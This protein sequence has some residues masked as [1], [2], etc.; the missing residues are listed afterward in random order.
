MTIHIRSAV[1]AIILLHSVSSGKWLPA[2]ESPPDWVSSLALRVVQETVDGEVTAETMKLSRTFDG[3]AVENRVQ[4]AVSPDGNSVA[5]RTGASPK[6]AE[7]LWVASRDDMEGRPLL[8][9]RW[10]M[11]P[12]KWSPDGTR[13]ACI[14]RHFDELNL[15]T[16]V[17]PEDDFLGYS[18]ASLDVSMGATREV[19]PRWFYAN[20]G[21]QPISWSPS[22]HLIAFSATF[23]KL[24]KERHSEELYLVDISSASPTIRQLTQNSF[25]DENPIF[26][27]Q[28]ERIAFTRWI[29]PPGFHQCVVMDLATGGEQIIAGGEFREGT[30][31][32]LSAGGGAEWWPDGTGINFWAGYRGGR[33]RTSIHYSYNLVTGASEVI[34]TAD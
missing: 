31:W 13:I 10:G 21:F 30:R 7:T 1:V 2:E 18:L 22:G 9:P 24:S 19:T 12:P 33:P 17:Y 3:H 27:P 26:S 15:V 20:Q 28:G 32:R 16:P 23:E 29:A 4:Y 14:L 5:L 25:Q 11:G 6:Y 34:E 8:T